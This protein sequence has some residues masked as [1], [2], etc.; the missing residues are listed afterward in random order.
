[1]AHTSVD[2]EMKKEDCDPKY[3]QFTQYFDE[4]VPYQPVAEP[5]HCYTIE[6]HKTIFTQEVFDLFI[7]Y[8][9]HV[10]KADRD[11]AL[12]RKYFCGAPTYVSSRDK[13]IA[14]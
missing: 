1:M 12:F 8:E 6:L 4:I 7:K 2:E 3:T 14:E 13:Q 11:E 9:K 10:H 5:K